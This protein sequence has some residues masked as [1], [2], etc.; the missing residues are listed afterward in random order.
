[1]NWDEFKEK[2]AFNIGREIDRQT[3]PLTYHWTI[4][5]GRTY[6]TK[7]QAEVMSYINS[8]GSLF[9]ETV[10]SSG[11]TA[12]AVDELIQQGIIKS[13]E[14]DDSDLLVFEIID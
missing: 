6:E 12:R 3:Q 13:V 9:V 2:L 7:K 5:D 11:S 8:K 1:M 4:G 14:S 10:L